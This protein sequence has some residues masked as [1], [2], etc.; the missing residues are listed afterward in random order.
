MSRNPRSPSGNDEPLVPIYPLLNPSPVRTR[1]V[2]AWREEDDE[3]ESPSRT[4]AKAGIVIDDL[5]FPTLI[6]RDTATPSQKKKAAA[7]ASK[8]KASSSRQVDEDNGGGYDKK[9]KGVFKSAMGR[10]KEPVPAPTPTPVVG[11]KRTPLPGPKKTDSGLKPAPKPRRT[12]TI[13]NPRVPLPSIPPAAA[14]PKSEKKRPR[15]TVGD[16]SGAYKPSK[17]DEPADDDDDSSEEKPKPRK[18]AKAATIVQP[19]NVDQPKTKRAAVRKKVQPEEPAPTTATKKRKA[20]AIEEVALPTEPAVKKPRRISK[21]TV[22][23]ATPAKE[24]KK[25]TISVGPPSLESPTRLS[26][27]SNPDSSLSSSL[28]PARA[29]HRTISL[30]ERNA[31]NVDDG[32]TFDKE[33]EKPLAG[34]DGDELDRFLAYQARLETQE[35]RKRRKQRQEK[36]ASKLRND[37]TYVSLSEDDFDRDGIYEE[38]Q[39]SPEIPGIVIIPWGEVNEVESNEEKKHEDKS[40]QSPELPVAVELPESGNSGSGPAETVSEQRKRHRRHRRQRRER[41]RDDPN[42]IPSSSDEEDKDS[43]NDEGEAE[44]PSREPP[45][46]SDAQSKSLETSEQKKRRRQQRRERISDDPN[47]IPSSSPSSSDDDGSGL[48]SKPPRGSRAS[49][50]HS[51]SGKVEAPGA[52]KV[53]KQWKD[54]DGNCGTSYAVSSYSSSDHKDETQPASPL[55]SQ[56]RPNPELD[57][58][59]KSEQRKRRRQRRRERVRDDPTYVPSSSA[60]SKDDDDDRDE[61]LPSIE[62]PDKPPNLPR[63]D[64][65]DEIPEQKRRRKLAKRKQQMRDDPLW[66][67][68]SDTS[69]SDNEKG[70]KSKKR[71][72]KQKQPAREPGLPGQGTGNETTTNYHDTPRAQIGNVPESESPPLILSPPLPTPLQ[73]DPD[74]RCCAHGW[75]MSWGSCPFGRKKMKT[76]K[77]KLGPRYTYPPPLPPPPT[78][79]E[80]P[81]G[82]QEV[83]RVPYRI[84]MSRLD[85]LI[86]AAQSGDR[87]PIREILSVNEDD[88]YLTPALPKHDIVQRDPL[89]EPTNSGPVVQGS[90]ELQTKLPGPENNRPH[91]SSRGKWPVD[92]GATIT[93]AIWSTSTVAHIEKP[94]HL[95]HSSSNRLPLRIWPPCPGTVYCEACFHYDCVRSLRIRRNVIRVLRL[96]GF[97]PGNPDSALRQLSAMLRRA[98]AAETSSHPDMDYWR[99]S[100]PSFDLKGVLLLRRLLSTRRGTSEAVGQEIDAQRVHHAQRALNNLHMEFGLSERRAAYLEQRYVRALWACRRRR[101]E[102]TQDRELGTSTQEEVEKYF[103]PDDSEDSREYDDDDDDMSDAWEPEQDNVRSGDT[104]SV[105]PEE[106]WDAGTVAQSREG[107]GQQPIFPNLGGG[108]QMDQLRRIGDEIARLRVAAAEN[109]RQKL[110]ENWFQPP[111]LPCTYCAESEAFNRMEARRPYTRSQRLD[112]PWVKPLIWAFGMDSETVA[113]MRADDFAGLLIE[114]GAQETE[115]SEHRC[116]VYVCQGDTRVV[117]VGMG[118]VFDELA[119]L[120]TDRTLRER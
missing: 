21:T 65:I 43:D 52:R 115:N 101:R 59:R 3:T 120:G 81:S 77:P 119:M 12:T 105:E 7:A 116:L 98:K 107:G 24:T 46:A 97:G 28:H 78:P 118:S 31:I 2:R 9:G 68:D 61:P 32:Q 104:T 39:Y 79:S 20:K 89:F 82:P 8:V 48:R 5:E 64:E 50:V 56:Q 69:G 86:A 6:R 1:M 85:R 114:R 27:S 42:Y 37:P 10:V 110:Q 84:N 63:N 106:G 14:A 100:F 23:T 102:I 22:A 94:D 34:D 58:T 11:K 54:R 67:S 44:S 71:K 38:P 62:P 25:I 55:P 40:G 51:T 16:D 73:P 90:S 95:H 15:G 4:L 75:T 87:R 30:T 18:R 17:E 66:S 57:E 45:V 74:P 35:E 53:H 72:E 33:E 80:G 70:K 112:K 88:I 76:Y 13:P 92:R 109:T 111:N 19:T 99:N 96:L 36:R 29:Q 108:D 113:S 26:S 41:M 47:Y 93:S 117:L 49:E 91:P 83:P 60:S 103:E